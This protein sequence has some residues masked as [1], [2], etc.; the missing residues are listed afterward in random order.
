[1]AHLVDFRWLFGSRLSVSD[2]AIFRA[3]CSCTFGWNT[4]AASSALVMSFGCFFVFF[5]MTVNL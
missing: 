3:K 4:W 1:M 5:A 2:S